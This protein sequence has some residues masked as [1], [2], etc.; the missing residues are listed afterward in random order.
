MLP[1]IVHTLGCIYVVKVD[2]SSAGY[3]DKISYNYYFSFESNQ[4]H[5]KI[6]L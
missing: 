4:L 5:T 2:P 3:S 6:Q 1:A